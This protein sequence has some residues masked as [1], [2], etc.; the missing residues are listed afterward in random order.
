MKNN[1][2][3]IFTLGCCKNTVDSEKLIGML[4]TAGLE[5][6]DN[7]VEAESVIINTCGFI[8][9][10]KQESIDL[11]LE[12]I[13]YKNT[14]EKLKV[15]V[16]GCLSQRYGDEL[17]AQLKEI[18]YIT[19]VDS[20]EKIIKFL[21]PDFFGDYVDSRRELLTPPH[22]AYL[23]IAEG[24]NQKCSFCIIPQIR[25]PYRSR[26]MEM[27]IEE[28]HILADTG[29]KE[30]NIIAQD[31]TYYGRDT[32]SKAMLG[33]LLKELEKIE[34]IKWIR[35]MYAY[36]A[37]FPKDI[38]DIMAK[39]EKI[40][41]YIDIPLQHISDKIL[42][43]MKRGLGKDKTIRLIDDIRN[44]IPDVIIRSAFIVGYPGETDEDF[45]ELIEF[46]DE[47]KLDRVG[48]FIYSPEEGTES[49]HL[50][51]NIPQNVKQAR[52]EALMEIQQEISFRKNRDCVGQRMR[53][54]IDEI[55]EKGLKCRSYGDAPDIDNAVWVPGN[56]LNVPGE[57]IDVLINKAEQYDIYGE[58]VNHQV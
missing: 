4:T 51:N 58:I 2:F 53:V 21:A 52:F 7:I 55:N 31:T 34:K 14:K 6:T 8:A 35:L 12:T 23:K 40:V 3:T 57:F 41:N 45:A 49:F 9:D 56:H 16:M 24:C 44:K 36:P 37:G 22:Y 33:S 28:A 54:L 20:E 25:G 13:D 27:L 18:D 48:A 46:L 29:V 15:I 10:A 38:L 50:S 11:I 47:A 32:H 43:S 42:K 30:L 19:G 1:K 5:Y 39:S 17:K 26:P